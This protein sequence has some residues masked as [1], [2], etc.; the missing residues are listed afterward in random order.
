MSEHLHKLEFDGRTY[1]VT[2][3]EAKALMEKW[4]IA[5]AEKNR[6]IKEMERELL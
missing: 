3:S 6:V 1:Y 5:E 4:Y 2:L